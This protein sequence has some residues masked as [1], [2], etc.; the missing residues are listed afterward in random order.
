MKQLI[1]IHTDPKFVYDSEIYRNKH[2][3]N[4]IIFIR[5]LDD[6]KVVS[7]FPIFY[8]KKDKKSIPHILN[9]IQKA[10]AVFLY[11]LCSF[12]INLLNHIPSNKKIFLRLFGYELYNLKKDKYI[13]KRI[14][15]AFFPIN[16]KQSLSRN[17]KNLIRQF[18]LPKT[19]FNQSQQKEIYSKIDFI[20][21]HNKFEYRELKLDFYL[22]TYLKLALLLKPP[23]KVLTHHKKNLIIIG[24]NRIMWNNH[25]DILKS[26]Y[27]FRRNPN[28]KFYLFFSYGS[29]NFYTRRVRDLS[30]HFNNLTLQEDFLNKEEFLKVYSRASALVINSYRQ[31]ALGN[32]F[33]GIFSGC[34]IYLNKR[35]S[36]FRW[37]KE[38][39][40]II[41]EVSKLKRDLKNNNIRLSKEEMEFNIRKY[42]E[43]R[44]KYSQKDFLEAVEAYLE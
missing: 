9:H 30:M 4:Q 42:K 43:E 19:S 14:Q 1:H 6:L 36:T 27:P 20:L 26:L 11:D 16:K 2:F 23:S 37:L 41:S 15:R 8:F 38:C 12:K 35:S 17:I 24:N 44:E 28:F 31:H 25:L 13:S 32:I 10:D 39:G 7:P 18:H 22:P 21:L 33:A 29:E 3:N 5:D 34:K 40:F